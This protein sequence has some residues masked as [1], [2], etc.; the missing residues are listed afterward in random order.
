MSLRRHV[1]RAVPARDVL[2]RRHQRR[3]LLEL[4]ELQCCLDG[5][6]EALL[7]D[8]EPL[9]HF[10]PARERL[11]PGSERLPLAAC[12]EIEAGAGADVGGTFLEIVGAFEACIAGEDLARSLHLEVV[13][14]DHRLVGEEDGDEA[15]LGRGGDPAWPSAGGRE[16]GAG[17]TVPAASTAPH[18][19]ICYCL[20]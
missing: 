4:A 6:D 5:G 11:E 7:G 3:G 16:A 19:R 13:V 20:T 1:R 18:P 9:A 8:L 12:R 10:G 2:D 15:A 14:G 17:A